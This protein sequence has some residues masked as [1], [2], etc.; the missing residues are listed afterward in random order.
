MADTVTTRLSLTKPE[1]TASIDTWGTKLNANLDSID[2]LLFK[3]TGDVMTG[4]AGIVLGTVTAPGLYFSG[5][6]NTG[7]F[8]P[9]ADQMTLVTAGASRLQVAADGS[10]TITGNLTVNGSFASGGS[11]AGVTTDGTQTLTNKTLTSPTLNGSLSGSYTLGGTVTFT[12]TYAGNFT[13]SGQVTFSNATAPIISAKIG[14]ASGQQHTLPAVT[15]DTIALLAAAQTLTNKTISGSA[16]TITNIAGSSITGQSLP[17]TQLTFAATQRLAGRNT[18]G[19][20]AGEEVTASQVL[21]WIGTT[22]GAVLY[23]GSGGWAALAPAQA[24]NVYR[25]GGAGA[26]PFSS[27]GVNLGAL[28]ATTAGT[29]I[30]FTGIPSWARHICVSLVGVSTNGTGSVGIQLGDSG[31]V[32][33]TGYSGSVFDDGTT[34]SFTTGFFDNS[35]NAAIVRHGQFDLQLVDPATNLWSCKFTLGYS[36]AASGR[37]GAGTKSTSATLDR[38]RLTTSNGTDTFDAGSVNIAY[39]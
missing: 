23:R 38:V 24:G 15:S 39:W 20:G 31:G 8:S 12:G 18:A 35:A 14:P 32:E 1:V 22:R 27:A 26:D 3:R 13:A 11:G 34:A 25:D 28:T 16:N 37:T 33:A 7:I 19:A 4:A 29:S 9:G 36:N 30:D 21:D 10:V 6:T 2:N 17:P 5:D